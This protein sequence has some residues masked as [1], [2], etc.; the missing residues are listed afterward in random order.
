[1]TQMTIEIQAP[2]PRIDIKPRRRILYLAKQASIVLVAIALF[3]WLAYAIRSGLARNGINFDMGFLTQSANFDIG[4]G[5]L[6]TLQGLR[7]FVSSDSNAQA[8]FLGLLNT[9]KTSCLAI[10]AAT[11]LGVFLGIARVSQNWLVRQFSFI[12]VEFVRNTPMLIQLVFWYFAVVLRMPALS[13][14]TLWL[15]SV[16]FSQQGFY[17]PGFE[18][19]Q[20]PSFVGALALILVP[21]FLVKAWMVKSKWLTWAACATASLIVSIG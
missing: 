4:E 9:L 14:A 6:L 21:V 20:Q 15:H 10:A 7:Q 5:E 3:A 2:A 13:D 1:M 16:L 17:F 8:L 19:T 12:F 18:I 11:V